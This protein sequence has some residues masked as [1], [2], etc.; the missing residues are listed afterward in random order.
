MFRVI[1]PLVKTSSA[2][3]K[4]VPRRNFWKIGEG[5]YNVYIRSVSRMGMFFTHDNISCSLTSMLTPNDVTALASS[6]VVNNFNVCVPNMNEKDK[7]YFIKHMNGGIP[8][9]IEIESHIF[10]LPTRGWCLEPQYLKK[11]IDQDPPNNYE[12]FF[13]MNNDN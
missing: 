3:G 7:K 4:T 13:P 8:I 6:R 5:R 1:K 10:G 12:S 9:K 11:I 2:L